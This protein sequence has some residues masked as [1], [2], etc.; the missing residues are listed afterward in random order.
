MQCPNCDQTMIQLFTSYVCNNCEK[1]DKQYPP[2]KVE[3]ELLGTIGYIHSH[4]YGYVIHYIDTHTIYSSLFPYDSLDIKSK[5]FAKNLVKHNKKGFTLYY[6]SIDKKY[7]IWSPGFYWNN[8]EWA[9]I[10]S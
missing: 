3:W 10:S 9:H 2:L 1:I 7:S 4:P 6:H 5:S 8:G